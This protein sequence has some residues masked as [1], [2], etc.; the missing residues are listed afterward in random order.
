M[1]GMVS[2]VGPP[3]VARAT[4]Q[5][6]ACLSLA[7]EAAPVA[8]SSREEEAALMLV[9]LVHPRWGEETVVYVFVYFSPRD[10]EVPGHHIMF[11]NMF[12]WLQHTPYKL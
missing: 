4:V 2:A 1:E 11:C 5:P 10:P 8:R 3:R 9:P 7:G 6:V 12:S